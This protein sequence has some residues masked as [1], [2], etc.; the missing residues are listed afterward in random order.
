MTQSLNLLLTTLRQRR[1]IACIRPYIPK[2]HLGRFD[3]ELNWRYVAA[4][5][6]AEASQ[7]NDDADAA[8]TANVRR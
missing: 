7:R 8:F 5:A 3:A 1:V 2:Y 6:E 4:A